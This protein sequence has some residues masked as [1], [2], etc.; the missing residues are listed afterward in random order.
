MA[1]AGLPVET[2]EPERLKGCPRRRSEQAVESLKHARIRSQSLG[3][4]ISTAK[5]QPGAQDLHFIVGRLREEIV[6]MLDGGNSGIVASQAIVGSEPGHPAVKD[7]ATDAKSPAVFAVRSRIRLSGKDGTGTDRGRRGFLHPLREWILRA[8]KVLAIE[9]ES[10]PMEAL[11]SAPGLET[12]RPTRRIV[13]TLLPAAGGPHFVDGS[14]I[15]TRP[16]KRGSAHSAPG[17]AAERKTS[18]GSVDDYGCA[19]ITP[20]R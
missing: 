12:G 1:F 15:S 6:G 5:S 18:A 3:N 19:A 8:E 13:P 16:H 11:R 2:T 14:L 4:G 17:S 20:A 7:A 10:L 9:D